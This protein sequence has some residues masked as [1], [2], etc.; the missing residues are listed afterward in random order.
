MNKIG[1]FISNRYKTIGPDINVEGWGQKY[2]SP[3]IVSP[4]PDFY[5]GPW[6]PNFVQGRHKF[7]NQPRI[8]G[9]AGKMPGNFNKPKSW[10]NENRY[11]SSLVNSDPFYAHGIGNCDCRLGV[12][13]SENI[14]IKQSG[15]SYLTALGY[16]AFAISAIL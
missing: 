7:R 5:H 1:P 16:L 12:D 11:T 13:S 2:S 10:S 14:S 8:L 15:S 6:M 4:N 3:Y 9:Q